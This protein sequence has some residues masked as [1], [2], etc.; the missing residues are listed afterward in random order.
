MATQRC[1][2]RLDSEEKPLSITTKPIWGNYKYKTHLIQKRIFNLHF[3]YKLFFSPQ[4]RR[5]LSSRPNDMPVLSVSTNW[6]PSFWAT[7]G[8]ISPVLLSYLWGQALLANILIP[9]N[10][11][12]SIKSLRASYLSF[13]CLS[14]PA[15]AELSPM[16]PEGFISAKT[17]CSLWL[18]MNSIVGS[19]IW[20]FQVLLSQND[21]VSPLGVNYTGWLIGLPICDSKYL[22]N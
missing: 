17:G 7:L 10:L 9:Y 5:N 3:I 1:D 6:S 11:L 8:Q 12:I 21:N 19:T 22:S 4:F 18:T 13:I 15:W 14:V 2:L 16:C 20:G